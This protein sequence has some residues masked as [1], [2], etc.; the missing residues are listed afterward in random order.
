MKTIVT[1][2]QLSLPDFSLAY[3][4]Y[5]LSDNKAYKEVLSRS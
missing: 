2:F 4:Y 5:F 3:S 1:A